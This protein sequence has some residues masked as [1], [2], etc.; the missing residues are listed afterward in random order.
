MKL[1][2]FDNHTIQ[3]LTIDNNSGNR[4][5]RESSVL[6]ASWLGLLPS[7][8][9]SPL[10]VSDASPEQPP[11]CQQAWQADVYLARDLQSLL[12]MSVYVFLQIWGVFSFH[13]FQHGLCTALPPFLWLQRH[14]VRPSHVGSLYRGEHK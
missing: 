11:K 13:C 4:D 14:R 2:N 10:R 9:R 12:N 1:L 5:S 8:G 3:P 6:R 7:P